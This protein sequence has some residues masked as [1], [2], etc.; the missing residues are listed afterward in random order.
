M[1]LPAEIGKRQIIDAIKEHPQI[2]EIL[3]RYGIGCTNCSIGTCL[4]ESVVTV[5]M[6][7]EATEAEIEREIVAYLEAAQQS[8]DTPAK[9]VCPQNAGTE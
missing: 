6:L 5:H 4:V 2:G 3:D 7:G 1:N 9:A 8:A